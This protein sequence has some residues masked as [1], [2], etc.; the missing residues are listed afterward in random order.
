M[1]AIY[2]IFYKIPEYIKINDIEISSSESS[3]LYSIF[4]PSKS[5][6]SSSSSSSSSPYS[7]KN[8]NYNIFFNF[9]ED[10]HKKQDDDYYDFCDDDDDINNNQYHN[11]DND[12]VNHNNNN[13]K[14]KYCKKVSFSCIINFIYIPNKEFFDENKKYLWWSDTELI[15]FRKEAF[16]EK[17]RSFIMNV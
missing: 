10:C 3:S 4:S 5:I 16:L 9:I 15:Q 11:Y 17:K 13:N 8:N 1:E 12:Y 7:S 2:N 6:L 14:K